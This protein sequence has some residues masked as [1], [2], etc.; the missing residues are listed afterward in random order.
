LLKGV[1]DPEKKRKIIGTTFIDVFQ[2]EAQRIEAECGQCDW[3][4][5][6]AFVEVQ[7]LLTVTGIFRNNLWIV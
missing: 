6:V 5:W 7:L 1:T 3:L 4:I 2:E